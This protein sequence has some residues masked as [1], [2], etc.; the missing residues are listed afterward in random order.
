MTKPST[1]KLKK[2]ASHDDLSA[3]ALRTS[4]IDSWPDVDLSRLSKAQSARV[5]ISSLNGYPLKLSSDDTSILSDFRKYLTR[6]IDKTFRFLSAE[7]NEDWPAT[8]AGNPK[9][10]TEYLART[11]HIFIG[12]LVDSYGFT[13]SSGL[14][15]TV[16]ELDA[17]YQDSPEKM[18]I[19]IQHTLRDPTS[20]IYQKL[21]K[22]Y[23]TWLTDLQNY[24]GGKVVEFFNT[25]KELPDLV[26]SSLDRYGADTLRAIRRMPA[27]ASAKSEEET[28]WEQMTFRERHSKMLESFKQSLAGITLHHSAFDSLSHVPTEE[29]GE[30]YRLVIML[31]ETTHQLPI[32]LSACPDRFAYAD[33]A[34]YVGYPFRTRVQSW[35]NSLGPLDI[36]LFFRTI[37]DSQIRRHLGNPDIHVTREGWGY[38]AA[39]PERYIQAAYLLN[40]TSSRDLERK[41]RQF[42]TWLD[43][44]EQVGNLI[45]RA[46]VRG[47]ILE[48]ENEVGATG[49]G[50][51]RIR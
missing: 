27:Y 51:S 42:L 30:R 40:C 36:I 34:A 41:V 43:E 39:D 44:Y 22:P 12:I 50:K 6:Q 15:A 5:F 8:G 4:A 48:A 35:N 32:I 31:G 28:N 17:A 47:R 9:E 24:R 49:D 23:Q 7:I 3:K 25:W 18:L 37:T 13:D 1:K 46:R 29:D 10:T 33:A 14:S 16:V 11:C 19:F 21:P 20:D 26:L 38:F 2:A 45:A